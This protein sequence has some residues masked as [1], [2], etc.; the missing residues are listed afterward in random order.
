MGQEYLRRIMVLGSVPSLGPVMLFDDIEDLFKWTGAGT[1]ADFVVEK[2]ATV[3]YNGS[4]SLHV[5]TRATA[6]A[7]NDVVN[8]YRDLFQRPGKRYSVECLFRFEVEA[9]TK[10]VTWYFTVWD[11]ATKH[12]I[13][14]RY[15]V[16]NQIWQYMDSAGS[17]QDITGSDQ[18]LNN[19]AWHRM[20]FEVDEVKKEYRKLV[21]D[22][23]EFSLADLSYK[24]AANT[25]PIRM[26]ALVEVTANSADKPDAYFDDF[27]VMEI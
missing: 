3:A 7:A 15:D 5:K 19:V 24:S 9:S 8:A 23:G 14:V 27:L 20:S 6:P 18:R 4:A 13:S 12:E 11:G 21:S 16:V 22:S 17:Y 1:G 25:D 10:Y 26:R 2:S